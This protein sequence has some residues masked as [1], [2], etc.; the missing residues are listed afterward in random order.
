MGLKVL[1][2]LTGIVAGLLVLGAVLIFARVFVLRSFRIASESMMPTL[3]AGDRVWVDQLATGTRLYNPRTVVADRRFPVSRLP[4]W[5]SFRRGDV[6]VFNCPNSSRN[7]TISFDPRTYYVKRC[8]GLPGDTVQIRQGC[9]TVL[10][11]NIILGCREEQR[12]LHR[13]I[14]SGQAEELEM[15]VRAFPKHE[16]FHWT[17]DSLGPIVVPARGNVAQLD[18]ATALIYRRVIQ[19]E[20]GLPLELGDGGR[21][22]LG[23]SLIDSYRFLDNYYY[24]CGDRATNSN[25]SRY[26]GFLPESFIVGRAWR[27]APSIEPSTRHIRWER[28]WKKVE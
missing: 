5:R 17:I 18:S 4:G 12:L 11:Q 26:W 8:I 13:L 14:A 27:V 20:Q 6:L 10:G 7:R 19:W 2:W 23:D 24:V 25:D 16:P 9:C 22:L 15:S 3:L 1:D 28:L 21:V